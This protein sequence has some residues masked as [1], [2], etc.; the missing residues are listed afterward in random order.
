MIADKTIACG[1]V[2]FCPSISDIK[3]VLSYTNQFDWVIV[4]L[5]SPI[6]NDLRE[7]LEDTH[8]VVILGEGTNDGL[9]IACDRMCQ[10][11]K[12]EGVLYFLTF[13]QDSRID[14]DS[15]ARLTDYIATHQLEKVGAVCPYIVLD[16][17]KE[18]NINET[19]DVNWCITSGCLFD[20]N[21]YGNA[22]EFDKNYFIDRLDRDFCKQITDAGYR[23]VRVGNAV[24]HQKLGETIKVHGVE[25]SS[26]SALRHY[27]ISR[28]RLYYNR[29]FR[30]PMHEG[31]L[32][33]LKHLYEILMFEPQK[34]DKIKMFFMG[35]KHYRQ[36]KLEK[37]NNN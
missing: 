35:I 19:I 29:K 10:W 26:H 13:D 18:K 23:I 2:L 27:Y 1:V 16:G 32:Q 30:V 17:N 4:Y 11:A 31:V 14:E 9:S 34:K 25:Y 7:M 5:N 6:S 24:L 12:H 28:N 36:G 21:L 33:M 37:F 3:N 20:L 22:V 8:N 15:I